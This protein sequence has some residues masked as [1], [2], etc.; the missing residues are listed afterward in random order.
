MIFTYGIASRIT[1]PSLK[2]GPSIKGL[3]TDGNTKLCCQGFVLELFRST[4]AYKIDSEHT[5]GYTKLFTVCKVEI[6][7]FT[8]NKIKVLSSFRL[9]SDDFRLKKPK[10]AN[11]GTL[12]SC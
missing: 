10:M 3:V 6:L 1:I 11:K 4:T 7:Q 2:L 9:I 12:V 8:V 5:Q